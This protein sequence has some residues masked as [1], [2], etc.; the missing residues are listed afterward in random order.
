M[1]NSFTANYSWT[2]PEVGA[3][4]N[5]WGTHLNADLDS[6]DS[7]V[8]TIS[9]VA[10]AAM[11]KSGGTFT[12]NVT[13]S[14]GGVPAVSNSAGNPR[15]YAFQTSGTERWFVYASSEAET[16]SN[17]G[18][19]FAISRYSDAGSFIDTPLEIVRSTGQVLLA[20]GLQ[21][22]GTIT[23]LN[24]I[25]TAASASGGA[26]INIPQGTAPTSPN[27]GDV[28]T[29]SSALFVRINGS[30]Q[31]LASVA[32]LGLGALAYL[33]SPTFSMA[34]AFQAG[35]DY[36]TPLATPTTTEVGYMGTPQNSQSGS[37][38][39][40]LADRGKE[41]FLT[42]NGT[43]T[44]PAN[45]SVAFPIGAT[46]EISADVGV[47]QTIAITTDT[48]RFVP[49]NVTGSRTLTGPGTAIIQKKKATEWW[50]KGDVA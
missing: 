45:A 46:I 34:G 28:W 26:G 33:N 27:N 38:T 39:L 44:I 29:T 32:G 31:Q 20:D 24:L 19:N 49:T 40:T 12:G 11:P 10:S 41:L 13:F 18:S 43:L 1:A 35:Q 48:L 14:S 21:V 15:G 6:I 47:T 36:T 25:Q 37:Y 3:D 8:F 4:T 7:T 50:I 2:K 16:G 23:A 42:G 9:G 17:A 30:T 22:S 5:A